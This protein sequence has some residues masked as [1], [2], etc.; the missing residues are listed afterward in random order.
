[1]GFSAHPHCR[2]LPQQLHFYKFSVLTVKI[3]DIQFRLKNNSLEY[4]FF[5]FL[6]T[7]RTLCRI[8]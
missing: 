5:L 8:A 7:V 3:P 1:M 2:H 6:S 4:H